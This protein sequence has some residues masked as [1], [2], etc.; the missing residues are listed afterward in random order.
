MLALCCG[1]RSRIQTSMGELFCLL[2]ICVISLSTVLLDSTE[3]LPQAGL[4]TT[5]RK[6]ALD[7]LDGDD[8]T[9]R[10]RA[11]DVMDGDGFGFEKRALDT[12]EG[13]DF[14][15]LKKRAL[16]SLEG[17]GFGGLNK[18]ALDS[19]DGEGFGGFNKRSLDMLEGDGFGLK[20]RALDSLE[21][22]GFGGFQKRAVAA[23][24][25]IKSSGNAVLLEAPKSK[26]EGA[27]LRRAI[28][29]LN[30]S[31]ARAIGERLQR[32]TYQR[33]V[34]RALDALEGGSFG[35]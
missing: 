32:S 29:N 20:K 33:S 9:L 6:R 10:K 30:R 24:D 14:V 17:D 25:L 2:L 13:D 31:R 15:G 11:L 28:E 7:S 35:F 1:S 8:F 4:L 21:G 22:N 23:V 19:L 12:L 27:R 26:A 3:A 34:K 18:R 5:L 16:D